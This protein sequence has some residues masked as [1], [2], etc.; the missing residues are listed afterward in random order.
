MPKITKKAHKQ[1]LH[2]KPEEDAKLKT[3]VEI[4]HKRKWK[5]VAIEMKTRNAKQC[6][7]RYFGHLEIG[8]DNRTPLS[9]QEEALIIKL[10]LQ[11]IGWAKIALRMYKEFKIKRTANHLK[12]NF[13]QRLVKR[14]ERKESQTQTFETHVEKQY[15]TYEISENSEFSQVTEFRKELEAQT[16]VEKQ[17]EMCEIPKF[18]EF[19]QVTEF[20]KDFK[21]QTHENYKYSTMF[22]SE[23]I[24]K[25][26][27]SSLENNQ[28][29]YSATQVDK[30]SVPFLCNP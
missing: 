24:M 21:A 16:H 5:D 19:S 12:N 15:E 9:E 29:T 13:N 14:I 26:E 11:G 10:R 25:I 3:L 8:I 2:W 28:P 22:T 6:R 30:M 23:F 17:P 18:S 4:Y 1:H 27:P 20:R 7:E